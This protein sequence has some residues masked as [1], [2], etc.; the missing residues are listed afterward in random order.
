M[1]I[2]L[3][4]P[5][6]RNRNASPANGHDPAFGDPFP[7]LLDLSIQSQTP[8]NGG[9]MLDRMVVP[10][11]QKLSFL[12]PIGIRGL[13]AGN[14][15]DRFG[16]P[17][18]TLAPGGTLR[19]SFQ[20]A[21]HRLHGVPVLLIANVANRCADAFVAQQLLDFRQILSHVVEQDC[22]RAVAQP[23]GDDLAHPEGSA[24]RPQAEG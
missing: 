4:I 1:T 10:Q 24:R 22:R 23:R 9:A 7:E 6:G 2:D 13:C 15:S 3:L 17:T 5:A 19:L 16:F 12:K 20:N 14:H 18:E 11:K 8:R 21:T